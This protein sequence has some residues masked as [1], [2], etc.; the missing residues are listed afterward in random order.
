MRHCFE[1]CPRTHT[2]NH[3]PYRRLFPSLD[4]QFTPSW[5]ARIDLPVNPLTTMSPLAATMCKAH[6]YVRAVAELPIDVL[7]GILAPC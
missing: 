6:A 1:P 4:A 5:A 2:H 7:G 3:T